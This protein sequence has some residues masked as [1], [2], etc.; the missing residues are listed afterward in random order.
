LGF[1]LFHHL[2]P[3]SIYRDCAF[4]LE[5][6]VMKPTKSI[7]TALE[8]ITSKGGVSE[9]M[10]SKPEG[11]TRGKI[12]FSTSRDPWGLG[13]VDKTYKEALGLI[14]GFVRTLPEDRQL[15][16]KEMVNWAGSVPS[17]LPSH[18]DAALTWLQQ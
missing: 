5:S 15:E 17:G 6:L 4:S 13:V 18:Q 14:A 1:G 2:V 9:F 16:I 7:K 12:G 3:V 10:L 8:R 11:D